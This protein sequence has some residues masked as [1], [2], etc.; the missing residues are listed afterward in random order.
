MPIVRAVPVEQ[1]EEERG[2]HREQHP[3]REGPDEDDQKETGG[4]DQRHERDPF[5]V[6]VDEG[7]VQH[8][9]HRVVQDGLAEHQRVQLRVD[10]QLLEDGEHGD[11][12]RGGDEGSEDQRVEQR[13][14][15]AD[16]HAAAYPDEEA[17]R[18]RGYRRARERQAANRAEVGQKGFSAQRVSPLEDDGREEEE[19]EHALVKVQPVGDLVGHRRPADHQTDEH[20]EQNRGASLVYPV[21]VQVLDP[22]PD[23]ERG[24]QREELQQERRVLQRKGSLRIVVVFRL[25][26]LG[27]GHPSSLRRGLE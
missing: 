25:G 6:E 19:E 8:D 4:F 5:V 24:G 22:Q 26:V 20:A 11:G 16:A 2:A 12:V 13:Q 14:A 1:L 18:E 9:G 3:H 15:V 21:D 7:P 27:D 17:Y 10:A 23:D